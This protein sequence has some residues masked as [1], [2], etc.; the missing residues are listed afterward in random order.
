MRRVGSPAAGPVQPMRGDRGGA[1]EKGVGRFFD[2]LRR[3]GV[4]SAVQLDVE[5]HLAHRLAGRFDQ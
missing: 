1:A 5:G 4:V 3:G 2:L